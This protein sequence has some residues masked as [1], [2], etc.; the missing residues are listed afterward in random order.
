M[1]G[2]VKSSAG[3]SADVSEEAQR[4]VRRPEHL[5]QLGSRIG[6]GGQVSAWR[7]NRSEDVYFF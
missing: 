1:D 6:R 7:G 4:G 5:V 2:D 3:A